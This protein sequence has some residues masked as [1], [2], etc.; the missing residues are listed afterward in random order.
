MMLN[1][2]SHHHLH[3]LLDTEVKNHEVPHHNCG[4]CRQSRAVRHG[5]INWTGKLRH[6]NLLNMVNCFES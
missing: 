6:A 5:I 1:N 3:Y 2:P 4:L